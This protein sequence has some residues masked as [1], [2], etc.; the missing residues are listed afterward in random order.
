MSGR[1]GSLDQLG[2]FCRCS[3]FIGSERSCLAGKLAWSLPDCWQSI[4]GIF[5]NADGAMKPQLSRSWFCCPSLACFGLECFQSI[6]VAP[7]RP[8]LLLRQLWLGLAAMGTLRSD[9]SCL[10]FWLS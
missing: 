2:E 4:P 5:N 8:L 3:F 7:N 9:F 1:L 6:Q 10:C